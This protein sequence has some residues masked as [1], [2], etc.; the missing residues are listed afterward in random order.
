MSNISS[1]QNKSFSSLNRKSSS[2]GKYGVQPKDNLTETYESTFKPGPRKVL[3]HSTISET[4]KKSSDTRQRLE[5]LQTRKRILIPV[6]SPSPPKSPPL[7][8]SLPLPKSPP[9]PQTPQLPKVKDCEGKIIDIEQAGLSKIKIFQLLKSFQYSGEQLK[10]NGKKT[11]SLIISTN[12][13]YL[14][15]CQELPD[16]AYQP[17]DG[18]IVNLNDQLEEFAFA[19]DKFILQLK[20]KGKFIIASHYGRDED[21][22]A[23]FKNH[24]NPKVQVDKL[25]TKGAETK[26]LNHSINDPLR[27]ISYRAPTRSSARI[28]AAHIE[29]QSQLVEV[30]DDIDGKFF[31]GTDYVDHGPIPPFK[32]ALRYKFY[33]GYDITVTQED[34]KSLHR[35]NWVN[36][37]AIDFG[38]RYILEEGISKN[39]VKAN[40]IYTFNSFFYSKLVSK[41]ELKKPINYY[42]NVK[43][44]VSKIDLL[45]YPYVILPV[46]EEFHWYCCIIRN[47]PDLLG[48]DLEEIDPVTK[49]VR[50]VVEI[51]VFD[52]LKAKRENVKVPLKNF[53]IDYC[54]DKFNVE[55]APTKITV[56]N[57]KVPRQNNFNDC[58]IHVL[59]NIKK[60]LNNII[61]CE[62]NWRKFQ[63]GVSKSIFSGEERSNERKYWID[64]LTKLHERQDHRQE[65]LN[66]EE[67]EDVIEIVMDNLP[68][69]EPL[70]VKGVEEI[71]DDSKISLRELTPLNKSNSSEPSELIPSKSI[72]SPAGSQKKV[73]VP[74]RLQPCLDLLNGLTA[75]GKNM[76]DVDI[77]NSQVEDHI[78]IV[79]SQDTQ[80]LSK[81]SQDSYKSIHSEELTSSK[82]LNEQLE[83][84][85]KDFE[86]TDEIYDLIN[87][88]IDR[89]AGRI[90]LNIVKHKLS[91]IKDN[92]TDEA[93]Q[94]FKNFLTTFQ[95]KNV[96]DG[97]GGLNI[98][99]RPSTQMGK[100]DQIDNQMDEKGQPNGQ[101]NKEDQ[102]NNVVHSN[103]LE[104]EDSPYKMVHS[105]LPQNE[106]TPNNVVAQMK[107]LEKLNNRLSSNPKGQFA[108]YFHSKEEPDFVE[109][110]EY[111]PEKITKVVRPKINEDYSGI[112]KSA[113]GL[114]TNLK[115]EEYKK[116]KYNTRKLIE[117]SD[118]P[119]KKPRLD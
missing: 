98:E 44:W 110:E 35:N 113:L 19:E 38:L 65:E 83:V 116:Q 75:D 5:S 66:E 21:I 114:T 23:Y 70:Q 77:L 45:S 71:K 57:A 41:D 3:F 106:D 91:K 61:Q 13:Q 86:L 29:K 115:S 54:K 55:I 26:L 100:E 22:R 46:N 82:L 6:E 47:L 40:E 105:G 81:E 112:A 42:E 119:H 33:N 8:K 79:N 117:E 74:E 27:N 1:L 103:F 94:E 30:L 72:I 53:I 111:E 48:T 69:K 14:A 102:S 95:S 68:T 25:L 31:S 20:E 2:S 51:F 62:Q 76:E 59:Y 50:G 104:K 108:K 34:F 85:L 39:I 11:Y 16:I 73:V 88:H 24:P 37:V 18:F 97:I 49:K 99:D 12:G 63:V 28:A 93:I 107:C 84:L 36:D 89:N 60:W 92:L 7:P 56:I 9:P 80:Q 15:V 109:S 4:V 58:G 87:Q 67:E 43:K 17:L 78:E 96:V 90:K 10:K 101:M 32:P 52:S 118:F 64:I